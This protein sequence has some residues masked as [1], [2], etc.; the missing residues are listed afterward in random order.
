M[1]NATVHPFIITNQ[2][3]SLPMVNPFRD[4]N[5]EW[6]VGLCDCCNDVSQCC[7]AHFCWCCFLGS[8]AGDINES[9]TS[10]CCL[11]NVLG[12]Y[13]MKVRATLKIRGDAFSDAC[14]VCWCPFC[15][16]LQMRNELRNRGLA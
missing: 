15:A 6:T 9:K 10:C 1:A 13:R 3:Q 16:G 8:L 7:Y 2:P 11:G 5:N 12:V 4:F 14:V